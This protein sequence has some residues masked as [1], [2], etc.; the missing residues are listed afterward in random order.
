M[1]L[2]DVEV[3]FTIVDGDIVYEKEH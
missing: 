1:N 2:P 3:L